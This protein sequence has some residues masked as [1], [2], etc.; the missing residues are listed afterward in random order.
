VDNSYASGV[1]EWWWR[2]LIEAGEQ[3]PVDNHD[4]ISKHRPMPISPT[5][6]NITLIIDDNWIPAPM[7]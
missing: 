3:P 1:S 7:N 5:F 4:G 2:H 6:Y